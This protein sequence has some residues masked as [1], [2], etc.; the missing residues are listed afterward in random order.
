MEEYKP[1]IEDF[2]KSIEKLFK[3]LL[4]NLREISEEKK[5]EL[6]NSIDGFYEAHSSDYL[7]YALNE[8]AIIWAKKEFDLAK[9]WIEVA[10]KNAGV[11]NEPYKVASETLAKF[12][13]EFN[14]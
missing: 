12:R 3:D 8:A 2:E 7:K 13:K 9:L 14:R 10:I 6:I 5:E 1:T 11:S 4:F